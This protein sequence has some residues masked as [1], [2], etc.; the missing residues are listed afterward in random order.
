MRLMKM[1]LRY[2]KN[3]KLSW[4]GQTCMS[5]RM[6]SLQEMEDDSECSFGENG[7]E[8]D[9]KTQSETREET[10]GGGEDADE[11]DEDI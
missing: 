11:M 9:E 10:E 2:L 3:W 6:A 7:G 8:N 1:T 4:W 5:W